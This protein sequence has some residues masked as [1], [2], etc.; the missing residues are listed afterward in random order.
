MNESLCTGGAD[1]EGQWA[2]VMWLAN[3]NRNDCVEA[4]GQH[5]FRC[6]IRLPAVPDGVVQRTWRKDLNRG[7]R[8]G[9]GLRIL[10]PD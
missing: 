7:C 9:R 1:K 8:R 3:W 6:P 2:A 4:R 10:A 5:R